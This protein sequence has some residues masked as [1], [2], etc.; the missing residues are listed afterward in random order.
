MKRLLPSL[1]AILII[2]SLVANGC[3]T[4][5]PFVMTGETEVISSCVTCHSD[6]DILQKVAMPES[7]E[8]K[9]ESTSGEG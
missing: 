2:I 5:E 4:G 3:R 9:S 7:E 1:F 8:K 6:K